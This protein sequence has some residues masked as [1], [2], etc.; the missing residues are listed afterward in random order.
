MV[1]HFCVKQDIKQKNEGLEIYWKTL[2]IENDWIWKVV[3]ILI[4]IYYILRSLTIWGPTDFVGES[5]KAP[6]FSEFFGQTRTSE[7]FPVQTWRLNIVRKYN[8]HQL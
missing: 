5:T 2:S 8:N 1:W 7:N 6:V 4:S 3:F